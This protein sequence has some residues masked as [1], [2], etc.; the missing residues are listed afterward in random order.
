MIGVGIALIL[1][2]VVSAI[3]SDTLFA[4]LLGSGLIGGGVG[5]LLKNLMQK[6][7]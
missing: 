5:T 4:T 2:G 3:V 1:A 7:E 6:K